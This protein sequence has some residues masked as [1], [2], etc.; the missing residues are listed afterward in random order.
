MKTKL[1][2]LRNRLALHLLSS[3]DACP[4]SAFYSSKQRASDASHNNERNENNNNNDSS[5]KTSDHDDDET[6]QQQQEEENAAANNN[7]STEEDTKAREQKM[8][9]VIQC[10]RGDSNASIILFKH[11]LDAVKNQNA[12]QLSDTLTLIR[13]LFATE[14]EQRNAII[15]VAGGGNNN[16]SAS[17]DILVKAHRV[18]SS[19]GQMITN[20]FGAWVREKPQEWEQQLGK[21]I[22]K[23]VKPVE[24]EMK[25]R[26]EKREKESQARKKQLLQDREKRLN[27]YNKVSTS[28]LKMLKEIS[29]KT[30]ASMEHTFTRIQEERVERFDRY[31]VHEA[32]SEM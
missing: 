10:C 28:A 18:N 27:G 13:S 8:M 15:K 32:M 7:D 23:A 17:L 9:K 16:D 26:H 14:I 4:C 24:S 19:T 22:A 2:D 30:V 12:E 1:I 6:Q 29:E 11:L 25:S 3:S 20:E 31:A 21:K 5:N